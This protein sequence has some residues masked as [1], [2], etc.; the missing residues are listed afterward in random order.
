MNKVLE[1]DTD[2]T[3]TY[4]NN[5]KAASKDAA[6]NPDGLAPTITITG[7][8]N[9]KDTITRTFNIGNSLDGAS[10]NLASASL[11]FNNKVQKPTINSVSAASK[12]GSVPVNSIN[13]TISYYTLDSNG[14]EV[15]DPDLI[16][17]GTKYV[18]LTGKNEYYGFEAVP[19]EITPR[20]IASGRTVTIKL[21]KDEACRTELPKDPVTN[22]LMSSPV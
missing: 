18:K 10:I 6:K 2:Y 13:Y 1:K 9:Y 21:Y 16:H 5:T 14:D 4:S 11:E 22:G 7:I 3:V 12:Y 15:T 17:V 19:Y 8:G 20:V